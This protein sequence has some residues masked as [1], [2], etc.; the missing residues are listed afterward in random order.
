VGYDKQ[1]Y[2]FDIEKKPEEKKE[3][4]VIPISNVY[5]SK[6]VKYQVKDI[7]IEKPKDEQQV[8]DDVITKEMEENIVKKFPFAKDA[9]HWVLSL[10]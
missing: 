4:E 9:P 5:P 2:N 7:K 1:E 6:V 8:F 3:D 10:L